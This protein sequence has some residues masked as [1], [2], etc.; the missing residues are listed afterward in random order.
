MSEVGKR[1]TRMKVE[2]VLHMNGGIGETSY[3][4]N[5]L[6]QKKVISLTKE[7]RDEAIKNLYCKT[8]PKRLGIA[9]LGCSSGPNTLLVI[10]E[11][12]K[13]VDKLCQEHNHESPEY[14]VFMNDLQG[15]DFNN[16]FRL[17]DRF[18]EKLNDEV[19]DGIGGPIFFYGAPGSFYGRI[20]PTKT[21]HF[22]HSSY[23]L[24]WLSQ[25][26]KG[27]ENNKGNIYMATTSPAN[28]LNAYH[29]QFQRDF[30]LFLKC[31]AEEL[32]DGGRMVLTI[33][34]RKSDDKYSKECCYIWEL[35]AVALNDMVL[36]G[37]IMEEQMDTFNIPQY[38][39]SPSEVKLEVLR[40]GS[41]TIDRLEVTEVH[42]NAYNDWNEVD[43][44][45]SLSKSLIDG[46]YNVTKCMRAVAEPLLVSHFGETIIEEV[47]GRYLEILVDR[48]SKERTEFINVSISLTKKV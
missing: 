10:S 4:N 28:V 46:A 5:S 41:F 36:E 44:R 19:E 3:S 47:F 31:R 37:I 27:V 22:I 45:S 39:P 14:Q 13:L 21:M 32:V 48:M 18:T 30:S 6:L 12:I 8:F 17:L 33:L 20:F 11:V 26:P 9:D 38:T 29:E 25:V 34:G 2:Q 7:M 15:N 1:E 23:S 16:I 42:W 35:L 40:E 43:F 24:Q